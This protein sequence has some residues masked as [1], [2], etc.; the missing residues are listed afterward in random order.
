MNNLQ[1]LLESIYID[2]RLDQDSEEVWLSDRMA[3]QMHEIED[4]LGKKY[5]NNLYERF[6]K[7]DNYHLYIGAKVRVKRHVPYSELFNDPT[8][9]Y[10]E[11]EGSFSLEEGREGEII[12]IDVDPEFSYW[13][14]TVKFKHDIHVMCR[15]EW[16][17]WEDDDE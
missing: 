16:L 13:D 3:A 9:E 1:S 10:S 12:E 6:L 8:N 14:C 11:D 2:M 7:T 5:L 4:E 15:V 17:D